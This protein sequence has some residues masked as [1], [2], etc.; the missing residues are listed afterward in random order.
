MRLAIFTHNLYPVGIVDLPGYIFEQILRIGF[1]SFEE[2]EIPRISRFDLEAVKNAIIN[3][4]EIRVSAERIAR[5]GHEAYLLFV[6][7]EEDG[8]LLVR[9]FGIKKGA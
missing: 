9:K 7:N 5:N 2:Y 4:R 1:V 6:D 3:I 8:L